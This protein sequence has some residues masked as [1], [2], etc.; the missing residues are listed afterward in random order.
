MHSTTIWA[1]KRTYKILNICKSKM[2][3]LESKKWTVKTV[4][5]TQL[6]YFKQ[7]QSLVGW[8]KG[9]DNI[10]QKGI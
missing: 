5:Q 4:T 10:S 7:S 6:F 1:P 8:E 9:Y 3:E 2:K